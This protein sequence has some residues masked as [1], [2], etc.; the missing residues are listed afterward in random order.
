MKDVKASSGGRG[1]EGGIERERSSSH[2]CIR[3]L[4]RS[5]KAVGSLFNLEVTNGRGTDS[6]TQT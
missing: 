3:A 1:G 6:V 5:S 4:P 2:P